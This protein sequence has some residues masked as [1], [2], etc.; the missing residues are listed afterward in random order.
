MWRK[1]LVWETYLQDKQFISFYWGK[2]K[3]DKEVDTLEEACIVTFV[4]EE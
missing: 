2:K 4:E 1:K 3:M